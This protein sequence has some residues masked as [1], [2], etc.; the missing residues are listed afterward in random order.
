MSQA[1]SQKNVEAVELD[2]SQ[3]ALGS[4]F[5]TFENFHVAIEEVVHADEG[6]VVTKIR[7]GGRMRGS[8]AEIWSQFFHVWSFREGKVVRWSSYIDRAAALEAVGLPEQD[9]RADSG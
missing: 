5:S 9:A 7:D 3:Q 6:R 1:N 2:A 8:S 4:Y